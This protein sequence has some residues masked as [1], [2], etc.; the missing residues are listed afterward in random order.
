M[1]GT[2]TRRQ[3]LAAGAGTAALGLVPALSGCSGGRATAAAP[4]GPPKRGG[5]LRVGVTGGGAADTL[6]PHIPATNP[7][8]AR[9]VNLF[10]PLLH[11]NHDYQLEMLVAESL[12]P[13]ADARTW[14]AVLRAGVRFHDGRPVTPADVVA[15]FAR[16]LDPQD[17]K[18]G[19]ASLSMLGEVVPTGDRTVEFRLTEPSPG[20]D[21]YLGQ[22]M[23]GIVPS[24]F[25]PANPVGTGPFRLESFTPGQQ[26]A[27]VRNEHYWRPGEPYLDRLVLINFTEDD[28]RINALLSSQVDAIDQV[29]VGLI[30]VLASD[31]RIR[32][33]RSETGTWLPFTMRVDRPPFDDARVRQ[34]FR[35]VVDREQMINQVLSGQGRVGNDLYAPFDPAYAADLPQRRRD[36]EGARRLLAEAGHANLTVELV[37]AP[38][39]AGAVE[40]AQVFQR[41]AA[42]AG[43]T[44]NL[45]R[46]DTTTFFGD[47]YL[48]WDFAQSFWYTRNYLPQVASGAVPTAP[49]NETHWADPE[50]LDLIARARSTVDTN[51]RNALLR[52]A[53]RIEYERGGNI[54]WGFVDQVDAH[55]VYVA[56][57]VP[58][59][60]GISL[61]GYQ[62]R[63]AWLG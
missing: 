34:A 22:Y 42:D 39:Q 44:V 48:S 16:V 24:G 55:Q 63:Q 1:P 13:S 41:Q 14:T 5:T 37:T 59:R 18:S 54:V 12:T 35:L 32:V 52:Q 36:V 27:F 10:E 40:A 3:F 11:R 49:F 45:R 43:I 62:F 47:D 31:E 53:Q 8:I 57:L 33:L 2:F 20:F 21:D 6:D 46:V 9:T 30:D 38:I 25:D 7:D 17:P 50:F 23:L 26:S 29:P 61:S 15:T 19:A 28:A 58:D 4:T 51:E 60:T 56:G